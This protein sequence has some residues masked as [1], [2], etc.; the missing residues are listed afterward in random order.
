[1]YS[2]AAT[3]LSAVLRIKTFKA[4]LS[5]DIEFFDREENSTGSLT[6]GLGGN[7]QK[8]FGL[9]GVTLGA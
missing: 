3:Q 7:S 4:I 8:I 2:H 6:T 1:M 9:A 5:Q